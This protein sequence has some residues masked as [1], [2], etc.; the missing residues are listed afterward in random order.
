MPSQPAPPD[1]A[2]S[3]VRAARRDV[4]AGG[5]AQRRAAVELRDRR[6]GR[7]RNGGPQTMRVGHTSALPVL[8]GPAP[9]TS[10]GRRPDGRRSWPTR[11][12]RSRAC[13]AGARQSRSRID[14]NGLAPARCH[15]GSCWRWAA[16][17]TPQ[18]PT[19]LTTRRWPNAG[20]AGQGSVPTAEKLR[21]EDGDPASGRSGKLQHQ[22]PNGWRSA[23]E[24]AIE[25]DG[26]NPEAIN[27]IFFCIIGPADFQPALR[28]LC[29]SSRA[30]PPWRCLTGADIPFPRFS[31]SVALTAVW[32]PKIHRH[33]D[34]DR[35]PGTRLFGEVSRSRTSVT[36]R[37]LRWVLIHSKR[38]LARWPRTPRLTSLQYRRIGE[39]ACASRWCSVSGF[40]DLDDL[41]IELVE[42]ASLVRGQGRRSTTEP[43]SFSSRHR[44]AASVPALLMLAD[45]IESLVA[46]LDQRPALESIS[47]AQ[48]RPASAPHTIRIDAGQPA[49][50]K[51]HIRYHAAPYQ[52]TRLKLSKR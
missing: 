18:A 15:G 17:T 44:G 6:C 10:A 48:G 27:V 31:A 29:P 47:R 34:A 21:G 43:A 13:R 42:N 52:A 39:T 40:A 20:V 12:G 30:G 1:P 50:G 33:G 35:V 22:R 7:S 4:R 26:L 16:P 32:A 41:I 2:A 36:I 8:G 24:S 19:R 46:R 9:F 14:H 5:P 28:G 45:G 25:R 3:A 51:Q 37:R 49:I 38:T 11:I 23:G